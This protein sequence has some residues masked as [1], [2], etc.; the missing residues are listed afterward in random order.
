MQTAAEGRCGKTGSQ[1]A[2]RR[3]PGRQFPP[4]E[5]EATINPAS[6]PFFFDFLETVKFYLVGF[7]FWYK[8]VKTHI[9]ESKITLQVKELSS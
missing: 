7:T 8:K 6:L 3:A 5:Q 1:Q 2:S 4:K 9:S